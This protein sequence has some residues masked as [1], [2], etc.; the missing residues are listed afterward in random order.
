MTFLCHK[1]LITARFGSRGSPRRRSVAPGHWHLTLGRQWRTADGC[2]SHWGANKL[3]KW[4][5]IQKSSIILD[6]RSCSFLVPCSCSCL[7]ATCSFLVPFLFPSLLAF[8]FLSLSSPA[9]FL[10]LVPLWFLLARFLLVLCLLLPCSLFLF[11]F[12]CSLFLCSSFFL[13][14]SKCDFSHVGDGMLMTGCSSHLW[15]RRALAKGFDCEDANVRWPKSAE[16]S[17]GIASRKHL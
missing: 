9:P 16:D 1:S 15:S 8:L 14:L 12:P 3:S 13:H 2:C 6:F 5:K 4:W 10:L 17:E 11:C 7:L